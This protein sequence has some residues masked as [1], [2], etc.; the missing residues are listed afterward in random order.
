MV[1]QGSSKK[2]KVELPDGADEEDDDINEDAL[3]EEG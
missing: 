3:S 1:W 2:V